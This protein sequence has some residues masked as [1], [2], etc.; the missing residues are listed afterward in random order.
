MFIRSSIIGIAF[1]ALLVAV[2]GGMRLFN[3]H[4][5]QDEVEIHEVDV[6][7]LEPPPPPPDFTESPPEEQQEQ[8][9]VTPPAPQ[10]DLTVSTPTIDQPLVRSGI[11]KVRL[12]T[13]MQVFNTDIAPAAIPAAPK[14]V[15]KK[16]V[17]KKPA[18]TKKVT[19]YTPKPKPKKKYTPKPKPAPTKSYYGAG[20]LDSLPRERSRGRFTWPRSAKGRSGTVKLRIEINTS[21]RVKVVQVVSSSDPALTTA[22]KKIA[23][24]SR[25]TTPTYKGKPVKA[26]FYKS[27]KLQK[28][29]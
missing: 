25:Y 13:P 19:K 6:F 29:R 20:D 4:V 16:A 2:L 23:T 10:L 5:V 12:D 15:V 17:V 22:A 9:D 11:T 28:P 24:G 14:P 1:T 8:V 27:Y 18:V 26:R 3:E 7:E 21:G